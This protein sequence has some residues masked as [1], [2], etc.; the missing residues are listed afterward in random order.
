[1]TAVMVLGDGP[2]GA[3]A[4][5]EAARRGRTTVL[6]GRG[7]TAPCGT[8]EVL[9]GRAAS[10]LVALGCY[11]AVVARAVPCDAVVARWGGDAY[12]ER[13]S[14]LT[15]GGLGWVVD[16]A[17][18]DP[19]LRALAASNGVRLT[20]ASHLVDA[21]VTV[22]ATGKHAP[23]E[24]RALGPDLL[25]LTAALP[26]S[27]MTS[28]S[29][30]LLVEAVAG[31]WW[32]AVSDGETC[33]LSLTL[34]AAST[35]RGTDGLRAAWHQA[36]AR[37]PAWLPPAAGQAAPRVRRVRSR[38]SLTTGGPRRAGDAALSVDPLSGHGLTLAL[39]GGRRCLDDG[40]DRWLSGQAAEHAAAGRVA[41]AEAGL[42]LAAWT[43]P[44]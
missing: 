5:I 42:E 31:A 9:D 39:E 26:A 35:P 33:A 6:V 13:T 38:L 15:P 41:Y 29:G 22:L 37:G 30:R 32:T 20:A 44:G 19:L 25:S 24:R 1:M 11:D 14:L 18:F 28:M 2:A 7:R 16:R 17:W 27:A 21:S 23:G 4:A 10:A 3:A 34:P 12:V 36:V 43:V 8:L 40:Y